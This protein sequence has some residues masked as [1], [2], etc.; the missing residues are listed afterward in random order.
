MEFDFY[1]FKSRTDSKRTK[2]FV[3]PGTGKVIHQVDHLNSV[4]NYLRQLHVRLMDGFYGR[5]LVGLAGIGLVIIS[6]TGLLI[7][8][9][10]MKKQFFGVI[11]HGKNMR[12]IF[13]DW[14]KLVGIAALVF[15]LMIAFTGAWLGLQPRLR[16][17]T[18]MEIPN[19]YVRG[20]KPLTPE[21]DERF[22]FDYYLA[23]E[24]SQQAIDNFI[25]VMV[26]PSSD[27]SATLE[28]RGDLKGNIYEPHINKVVL[29]KG[30]LDVLFQ[31]DISKQNFWH[32]LYF[33]QEGLH[34]GR[35]AGIGVKIAYLLLGLTSGFLSIS[36]FVIYLKRKENKKNSRLNA[37]KTVFLYSMGTVAV[38]VLL[39]LATTLIG[40]NYVTMV[41]TPLVYLFLIAFIGY[42]IYR[43]VIKKKRDRDKTKKWEYA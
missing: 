33:I 6:I 16:K 32:R 8:G 35:F 43:R 39:G 2:V 20:E 5:Q 23:L 21:E 14:H 10:F 30:S 27:G 28:I 13:A 18:G 7:Y 24:K 37:G 4:P 15:N 1:S 11:R 34:F 26:T 38:L 25:P 19:T 12:I 3:D 31:Y 41:I 36:G 22:E 40:Y 17:W 42:Q 29:D 9:D